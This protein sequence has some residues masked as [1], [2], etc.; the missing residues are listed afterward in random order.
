MDL[1]WKAMKTATGRD[2]QEAENDTAGPLGDIALV[3]NQLRQ[4]EDSTEA[5]GRIAYDNLM[6]NPPRS[7][8]TR[9]LLSNLV[10]WGYGIVQGAL[11]GAVRG[12]EKPPDVAGA[13]VFGAALYGF[14]AVGLPLLGFGKGPTAHPPEHH[15][16]SLG[17][18]LLY[19]LTTASV[20]QLLRRVL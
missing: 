20:T 2:L 16:A 4:G 19:G 17:G 5:V 14:S 3:P 15:A 18:H 12:R 8:E 10:H 11:Y 9:G 7:E 6:G 1:Y 13:S